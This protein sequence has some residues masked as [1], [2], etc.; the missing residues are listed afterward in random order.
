MAQE[1]V[2]TLTPPRDSALSATFIRSALEAS[3]RLADTLLGGMNA[4]GA[5]AQVVAMA[6]DDGGAE[7]SVLED[8]PGASVAADSSMPDHQRLSWA[9]RVKEFF[10]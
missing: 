9:G 3:S 5:A 1:S 8:M 6:V 4:L 10:Q 2:I 7:D